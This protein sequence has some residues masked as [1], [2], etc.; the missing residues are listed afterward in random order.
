[1]MRCNPVDVCDPVGYGGMQ[2]GR[3]RRECSPVGYEGPL[4]EGFV[5]TPCSRG[6][7]YAPFCHSYCVS[8]LP[9]GN[10]LVKAIRLGAVYVTHA[11]MLVM[12]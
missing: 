5:G 7:F 9:H 8:P 4:G 6:T 1:M 2:P 10:R 11:T 3:L 12:Q